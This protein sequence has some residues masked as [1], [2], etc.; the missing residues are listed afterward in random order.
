MFFHYNVIK[1]LHNVKMDRLNIVNPNVFNVSKKF[2][3]PVLKKSCKRA[4][5]SK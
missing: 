5:N 3:I 4:E 2:D 1:Y